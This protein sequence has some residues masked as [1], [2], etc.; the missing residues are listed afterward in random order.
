MCAWRLEVEAG[1]AGV[2]HR[3]SK[4][5]VLLGLTGE[6][7]ATIDGRAERLRAGDVVL[8]P[9]GST[10]GIDNSSGGPASAWVTT[11]VG[12]TA[13]LD[14]GEAISPPWVR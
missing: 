4:E 14:S 10:F 9:A 6:L 5:E 12:L 1:V 2:P 13:T 11:S 3:V 7:T 8:V